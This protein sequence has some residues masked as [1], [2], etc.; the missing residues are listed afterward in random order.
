MGVKEEDNG[1][2]TF[3]LNPNALTIR[4]AALTTVAHLGLVAAAIL[5][6]AAAHLTGAPVRWLLPMH[7]PVILAGL[8][9]GWRSGLLVGLLAPATNF[10]LTGYPLP[11][12]L[13]AMTVELMVYGFLSGFLFQRLHWRGWASVA[14]AALVGRTA[15]IAVVLITGGYKGSIAEY[16]PA[17]LLPG[18]TAGALQAALLPPLA[19]RLA[20]T[21]ERR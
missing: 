17:A 19:R 10:L 13:P 9:L 4:K 8:M 3:E 11:M 6:P 5:L 12:V 7:W 16:L 20:G 15:F 18:L 1:M 2:A 14:A 21:G